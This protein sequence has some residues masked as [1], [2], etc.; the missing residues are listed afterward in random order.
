VVQNFI[1]LSIFPPETWN[2]EHCFALKN[3]KK[4]QNAISLKER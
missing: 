4:S 2:M 1:S 3:H